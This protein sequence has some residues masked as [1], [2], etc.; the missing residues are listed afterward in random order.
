MDEAYFYLREAQAYIDSFI[1]IS[2]EDSFFE[3]TE[4]AKKANIN[5]Q[6]ATT[7]ALGALKNAFDA[8]IELVQT[9]ISSIGNFFKSL[10]SGS[11]RKQYDDLRKK[12]KNNPELGKQR[13]KVEDFEE[14]DKCYEQALKELENELKKDDPS[15]ENSNAIVEK[16][17]ASLEKLATEKASRV[18]YVTTLDTALDIADRNTT[19]AKAMNYALEKELINLEDVRKKLGDK[20]VDKFEKKMKKLSNAGIIHRIYVN[21]IKKKENS[22]EGVLKRQAKRLLDF[23]NISNG[24]FKEGEAIVN[25][26]SVIKG[27]LKHPVYTTKVLGG[28][29][30]AANL[31]KSNVSNAINSKYVKDDLKFFFKKKK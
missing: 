12:I 10:F 29:E 17:Q 19:L 16:L 25:K 11:E 18:A 5:N 28:P 31:A 27:A 24:K 23:T 13:V 22:L 30:N 2:L 3:A 14:Y 26:G 20:E 6:K 15:V 4:E 21:T 7:G 8:L 9:I 1:D